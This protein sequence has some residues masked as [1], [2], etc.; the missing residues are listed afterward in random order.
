MVLPCCVETN[1]F[2]LLQTSTNL[3]A[4][5]A[6]VMDLVQV[7]YVIHQLCGLGARWVHPQ[8]NRAI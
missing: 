8:A 3:E 7:G 6:D 4:D 1:H 2:W 5:V